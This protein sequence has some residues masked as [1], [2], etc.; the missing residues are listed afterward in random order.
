MAVT[1]RHVRAGAALFFLL[2]VG[3]L[4]FDLL[5]PNPEQLRYV[6]GAVFLVG[7]SLLTFYKARA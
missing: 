1:R 2:G 5:S 7:L 3:A 6:L 4:M